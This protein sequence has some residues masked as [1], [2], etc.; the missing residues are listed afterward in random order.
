MK[1]FAYPIIAGCCLIVAITLIGCPPSGGGGG[2]GGGAKH[3]VSGTITAADN[4]AI[5]SDVNDVSTTP[6][7]NDSFAT[8]QSLP[9]PVILGGYVNV[10]NT[11]EDGNSFSSG[12]LSD[13]Y[14]VTLT[15]NQVISLTIADDLADIDL[16]LYDETQTEIDSSEGTDATDSLTA[17]DSGTYF[18]EVFAYGDASNYILVVGQ[19]I[20]SATVIDPRMQEDFM[21]GHVIVAFKENPA[22]QNTGTKKLNK[23]VYRG[24]ANRFMKQGSIRVYEF[25]LD[26]KAQVFQNLNIPATESNRAL[27]ETEDPDEQLK[28]D[29]LRIIDALNQDPN[30]RY[31]EPNYFRYPLFVPDDP[32]YSKQWHYPMINMPQAWEITKGLNTIV[33]VIDTGIL[34]SHPDIVGQLTTDGY[35]FISLDSIANDSDPGIDDDPEDPGDDMQ[36]GSSF[37]G[38]HV[39]GT[40]AAASNNAQG[41]AGVAYE[42]KIMPLRA[43][44]VGGGLSSDI[45]ECIKYAA[46]MANDSSTLPN[47]PADVINMS[48]GG[49]SFS[50]AEQDIIDLVRADGIIVVAAAGNENTSALSYPASYDN[51]IS[52]SAVGPN[53]SLSSYSNYGT[54]IDVAAPGGDFDA[55]GD[56]VYSTSGDD[57]GGSSI[58]NIYSFSCGTSMASP[59]MAGVVALM[60]AVY[61][62]G[63]PEDFDDFIFTS[64]EQGLITED[65]AGN[66]DA[67]RDNQFGYGLIDAYKAVTIAADPSTIP[68]F[69]V[70][71]ENSLNFGN[72]VPQLTITTSAS[73][74]NNP[75]SINSVNDDAA[76]LEV[77]E[78]SVD[79]DNLGDY[80]VTVTRES[81]P[82]GPYYATITFDSTQNDVE[83]SVIM[84]QG[85]VSVVGNSGFHYVLLLNGTTF[86]T[87]YQDTVTVNNGTY[88][89][90][91]P[92]VAE[93]NYV[94]FAGTD[95]DND[96]YIGD[97]GEASGAYISLD[98]PVYLTVD[99]DRSGIDFNTVFEQTVS[100]DQLSAGINPLAGYR[101]LE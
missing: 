35:D 13:F 97:A 69:L 89:F 28:L 68:T 18:I 73:N 25:T 78:D 29:T 9:N 80:L 76:W 27:Y 64:L 6:V 4:S 41:V 36:G 33:A 62:V 7:A 58:Q 54:E 2:G 38:T 50:Q 82:D 19:P 96:Y 98:Q 94:V 90:S 16:F 100:A 91:F 34:A 45:L 101:R 5:D 61:P 63:A 95:S 42:A 40:V 51:V 44:G 24:M 46:G 71:S 1:K 84:Y 31:A 47:Q 87:A 43:L 39:S 32:E 70:V 55:T 77:T 72:A 22:P 23:T 52:V 81:L 48:L 17:P 26:N 15:A 57:T 49:G 30:V 53:K 74:D 14:A 66:G 65:L 21:P 83:V 3:S 59:H 85:D 67:N 11:G 93:G 20:T 8:A 10:P 86:A 37:H 88:S 12:D 60:K 79:G 56:C 75:L 99:R 92:S